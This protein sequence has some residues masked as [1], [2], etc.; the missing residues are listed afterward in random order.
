MAT[1]LIMLALMIGPYL[2]TRSRS[3]GAIGLG[4]LFVFTGS[5]HFLQTEP[6]VQMLPPWVP[7]RLTLVQLT[8][9]LE[10]V[11]ALNFVPMPGNSIIRG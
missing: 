6:M 8:G 4:L 3:A 10:F 7:A 9:V 2:V 5:G 1:P 11:I